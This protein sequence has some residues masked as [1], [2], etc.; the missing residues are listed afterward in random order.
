[1]PDLTFRIDAVHRLNSLG[2][3]FTEVLKGTTEEGFVAEWRLAEIMTVEGDR[4]NRAE[5]FDESDLDAALAKFDEL[6]TPAPDLLNAA[7]RT[8]G[9]IV[10]ACNRRD[11]NAFHALSSED[12]HLDDRRKGLR[13]SHTGYARRMAA[14]SMCAAP[15]GWHM[16]VETVAIRGNRL[17][18]TRETWRDFGVADGPITVET[19]TLTEVDNS[20]LVIYTEIF[21][22]EDI[23]AAVAELHARWIARGEVAY[24]EVIEAQRK[25]LEKSNQHDWDAVAAAHAGAVTSTIGSCRRPETRLP[26]TCHQCEQWHR[27]SLISGLKP[28]KFCATR[29]SAL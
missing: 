4:I 20:D 19:L 18:L 16:D 8:W 10:D 1:M 26:T 14:A 21:D 28:L 7:V 25:I 15:A 3:V 22:P 29:R 24:P 13:A 11:S 17:G 23:D 5:L 9:R 12:G 2:A 6:T 27:S